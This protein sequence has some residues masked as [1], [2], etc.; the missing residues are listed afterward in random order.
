M[1]ADGTTHAP[2]A[3]TTS[4]AADQSR[5]APQPADGAR[6]HGDARQPR[7]T[8]TRQEHAD[9]M[10]AHPPGQAHEAT[11][12][13][14]P[15]GLDNRQTGQARPERT[16]G[17]ASEAKPNPGLGAE[18][19]T[20]QD[21]ADAMLAHP[22]GHARKMAVPADEPPSP[23]IPSRPDER[24]GEAETAR[25]QHQDSN[26]TRPSQSTEDVPASGPE[27]PQ[28]RPVRRDGEAQSHPEDQ[29]DQAD[30][31]TNGDR[32]PTARPEAGNPASGQPDAGTTTG[33]GDGDTQSRDRQNGPFP[34]PTT[35]DA[36][37]TARGPHEGSDPD[38]ARPQSATATTPGKRDQ[39]DGWTQ[40]DRDRVRALYAED[41]GPKPATAGR[42]R[43]V[44]VV[45]DKPVRSPGDASDLPPSGEE[46]VETADED[47]SRTEK[48]R[49]RLF[50][51]IEDID[52]TINDAAPV[53]QSVLLQPPP[54]GSP[55]V[56][57]DTHAH[58]MPESPPNA[59]P[60]VGGIAELTLVASVLVD[61][62]IHRA[63]HKVAN[64]TGRS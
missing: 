13:A 54:T 15:A 63:R 18:V 58:W 26:P 33:P 56:I 31:A 39:G 32:H 48:F 11:S 36:R 25:P 46:L 28:A 23:A 29:G 43:G 64:E 59:T 8:P 34:S 50:K 41:F 24:T 35:A 52:D 20:R 22:P 17:A 38:A 30:R 45:G 4:N 19:H 53:V 44:N 49:N 12:R 16:P 62:A 61:R 55:G 1:S 40:A 42:D 2:P 60:S 7:G 57:A 21:H 37:P 14:A 47:D 6:Q 9:A 5:Q 10:L 3:D 51:S 27:Q